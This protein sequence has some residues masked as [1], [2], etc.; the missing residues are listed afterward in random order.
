[1]IRLVAMCT[2]AL[3]CFSPAIAQSET[4]W[5]IGKQDQS[6]L[7]FSAPAR[8]HL[9]YRV[10]KSDWSK[11]WP[12][13]QELG[14]TYEIR[15]D[16]KEPPRGTF[17]LD[18]STL[19][20]SA[21]YPLIHLNINGHEG[22]YY[23]HPVVSYVPGNISVSDPAYSSATLAIDI[24]ASYLRDK[25]NTLT[26]TPALQTHASVPK[27]ASSPQ[28]HY[29][30]VSLSNEP[31]RTYDTSALSATLVPTVFYKKTNGQ[32]TELVEAFLRYGG[33]APAQDVVLSFEGK[34]YTQHL[35]AR[36]D[37]GEELVEFDV[38]EWKGTAN[39]SLSLSGRTEPIP[40]SLTAERKWTVFVVPNTHLDIGFTDYQ[41]KVAEAQAR[42]LS[43]AMDLIKLNPDFRFATDA[44]WNVEQFM[45]T[46]SQ[47]KQEELID[48]IR[49]GKIGVPAQYANLLTGY[50]TLETL[51]RSLYYS[52]SLSRKYGIPFEYANTTDVPTQ[53]GAYPSILAAA[54][55]R[56]WI[57]GGNAAR[58]PLLTAE[59]WNEK[60]PF[61]WQGPDGKRVLFWYSRRYEQMMHV[62]GLPPQQIA[63][64]ETLPLFL[65][66]YSH[67]DYKPD[68]TML[69][70][71][72]SENTDLYP[73]IASFG[74]SWNERFAYPRLQY[75]TF[76]DFMVYLDQHYGNELPVRTGDMGHYWEDGVG[77]DAQ[78]TA[79]DRQNQSDAQSVE[80]MSTITH[81]VSPDVN[82]PKKEL[83]DAW[84]NI[85]LY[86]E[87]TWTASNS[88]TQPDS[89]QA[90]KQLA[91]KNN[92]ATQAFFD[93]DD[94][95]NRTLS[96]LA[97]QIHIP[98]DTLVVFNSLSW[99]R[100][101]LVETDLGEKQTLLDL[102]TNQ[103]VPLEVLFNKQGFRHVRFLAS[104]LPAA[105]YKCFKIGVS[106]EIS[107]PNQ[108]AETNRQTV[109]ENRFY[110]L[111][112]D[113]TTG[114]IV[115]IVDKDLKREI[116]DTRSPYK[117]GQY[118]YVTGGDG[119]T[120]MINSFTAWPAGSLTVH[121]PEHSRYIGMRKTAWG[122]VIDINSSA[123]NTP[124][125][126]TQI[127]LF[128]DLKKIEFRYSLQKTYTTAKEA[129][130]FAFPVAVS[131]PEFHYA[132]QQGW[133]NPAKDMFKGAGLEWFSVQKWMTVGDQDLTV[134]IV[135]VDAPLAAF[136]DINRGEWPNS[137]HSKSSTLFSYV[138]N[139]Y[140]GVNFAAGQGGAFT[141]RYVLTSAGK[142]EPASLT[143]LGEESMSGVALN[144]V[145][146]RDKV[147]DPLRPLPPA[148]K[149]FL[150]IASPDVALV[151]WKL[152]EDGNGTIL[153]LQEISGRPIETD[154]ELAGEPLRSAQRCNSVEDNVKDIQVNGTHLHLAFQ[155]NEVLTVRLVR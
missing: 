68:V 99:Q 108:Q 136:G 49:A 3:S 73:E 83:D 152:A 97:D 91:T 124:V 62:L 1:M 40:F 130:Y 32:L 119:K 106:N 37:A 23:L 7:E 25:E 90:V 125:I 98:G 128:D 72:Q 75:A 31:Q 66:A 153:R 142:L 41:G 16:L 134:G 67:S 78:S 17:T 77:T 63:T 59:P 116:V 107:P 57:T 100:S 10:G 150:H 81:T 113:P 126:G 47:A 6:T 36:Q 154:I 55:I 92:Y 101:A 155:P 39:G 87:H 129:A 29:D 114:D 85:E 24:P 46:R 71:A 145:T 109:I 110:R 133:V 131:S 141:F 26:L 28:L 45:N 69:Y 61:W 103:P 8:T 33:P 138:M 102:T 35:A 2:I 58:A 121:V 80:V 118:L 43:Q 132:T 65:Q 82:P 53:S 135:P 34:Q 147:G 74:K 111:T 4:V 139:N 117:F 21:G 86:A 48:S 144:H 148:G 96:Q 22:D 93:L 84:K 30:A 12:A 94:V 27:D 88:V 20:Y 70:G 95:R 50:A 105:G 52:K 120:R 146:K 5:E 60:S 89:E 42:T 104:D 19:V 18:I 51:N 140:W 143:R 14:S 123:Q 151:T 11:D 15:F 149:S 56:Y 9:L 76:D 38:K 137:F 79:L 112:L 122:T 54:G 64:F 127:L 115:S 44:S 13:L